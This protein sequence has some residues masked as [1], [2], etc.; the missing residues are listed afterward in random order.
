MAE[1]L[2]FDEAQR[3]QPWTVPYRS[4]ITLAQRTGLVP[5][6]LGSHTALH[7]AKSVGKLAAVYEALDHTELDP[8][9]E[10]V[11]TI[12]AMAADLATAAIRL[13]NL[14]GFSLADALE[15]R[16]KEKNGVGIR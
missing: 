16:V 8:T 13:A 1:A 15:E 3:N 6:I 14:H 5:H 10:Q 4:G 2:T 9:D 11:A 7:A 12:R